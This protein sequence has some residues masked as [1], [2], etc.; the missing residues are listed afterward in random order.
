MSHAREEPSDDRTG[1][2]A[3][4]D[5]G[6]RAVNGRDQS[7][8]DSS[9]EEPFRH[10]AIRSSPRTRRDQV[11]SAPNGTCCY[12]YAVDKDRSSNCGIEVLHRLSPLALPDLLLSRVARSH[13]RAIGSICGIWHS[14]GAVVTRRPV[15]GQRIAGIEPLLHKLGKVAYES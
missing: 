11:C 10:G 8:E 15:A 14:A 6:N 13:P 9:S 1:Q 5:G 3:N 7:S 12:H 2:S 4:E